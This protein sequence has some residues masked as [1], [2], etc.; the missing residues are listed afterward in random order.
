MLRSMHAARL[1]RNGRTALIVVSASLGMLGL[2]YASAPLYR[3]FCQATGFGGTTQRA[4]TGASLVLDREVT[5]RFDASVAPDLPWA[6]KPEQVSQ[7]LKVGETQLAYFEAKNLTNLPLKGR[8]TFN[9]TPAKA[10]I[11]FKKIHCFCFDE[12]VL[13]PGETVSMPV[14]YFIDPKIADDPNLDDVET[15]TLAYT[16]FPWDD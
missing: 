12:Q 5:V 13:Q 15:V 2:A 8:A 4:E 1:S 11:Y 14:S 6:F 10:G 7:E 3:L 9:V 16:F